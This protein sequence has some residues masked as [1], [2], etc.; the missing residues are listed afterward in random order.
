[1]WVSSVGV[2]QLVCVCVYSMLMHSLYEMKN[3]K[4]KLHGLELLY[5]HYNTVKTSQWEF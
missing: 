4:Q 1:M 2:Y 5:F 3:T